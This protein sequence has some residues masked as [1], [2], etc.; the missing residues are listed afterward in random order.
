M[1]TLYQRRVE[2][3]WRLLQILASTN[4]E[5]I[6]S[7]ARAEDVRGEI[8]RFTLRQTHGLIRHKDNLESDG[9]HDVS[10]HFPQFFPSVPIEASLACPVFHPNVHPENGFVCLWGRFSPGDT[11]MEAISQLQQVITWK[12]VNEDA[13]HLM[14]PDALGWYKDASREIQLPLAFQAITKPVE[15]EKERTYALRPAESCRRRLE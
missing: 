9:S 7:L 10:L 15:V 12:L 3:E 5:I 6:E 14:Q 11:V 2:Q 8:F 4:P 1:P 13:N